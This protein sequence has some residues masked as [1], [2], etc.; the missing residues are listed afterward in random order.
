MAKL[1]KSKSADRVAL[2]A[3]IYRVLWNFSNAE[4]LPMMDIDDAA[5]AVMDWLPK[6]QSS[7][8]WAG[9]KALAELTGTELDDYTRANIVDPYE[10][11][12]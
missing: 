11:S 12:K 10:E 1:S 7:A 4:D 8:F 2:L 5:Q 6:P 3:E 9:V